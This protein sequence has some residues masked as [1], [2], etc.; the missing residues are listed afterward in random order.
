MNYSTFSWKELLTDADRRVP[1]P[2]SRHTAV[3]FVPAELEARMT[4]E[5]HQ[6]STVT[7]KRPPV[8]QVS[9]TTASL[10]CSGCGQVA[11]WV[12]AVVRGHV[13]NVQLWKW[14][15]LEWRCRAERPVLP[16]APYLAQDDRHLLDLAESGEEERSALRERRSGRCRRGWKLRGGEIF[17]GITT[18]QTDGRKKDVKLWIRKTFWQMDEE[19]SGEVLFLPV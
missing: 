3:G 2:L 16:G 19:V 18:G 13:K 17:S 4:A 15:H 11:Q 14:T 9:K 8:L 6:Q 7:E 10:S 5:D 12:P 1:G